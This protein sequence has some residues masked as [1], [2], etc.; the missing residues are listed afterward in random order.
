MLE[1]VIGI[2]ICAA[3]PLLN[4][5]KKRQAPTP[6]KPAAYVCPQCGDKDCLCERR[7]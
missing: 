5:L 7:T 1:I 2:L 4:H 3:V 6:K